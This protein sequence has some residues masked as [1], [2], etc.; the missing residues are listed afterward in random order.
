VIKRRRRKK[1]ATRKNSNITGK[2]QEV[3]TTS[4]MKKPSRILE[5]N[6]G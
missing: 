1:T 3:E 6:N 5:K 4:Q 2:S